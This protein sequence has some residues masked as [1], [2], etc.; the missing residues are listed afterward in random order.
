MRTTELSFLA[1]ACGGRLI[2]KTDNKVSGIKIDSR[3]VEPGDMFVAVIGENNDGHSFWRKA[4]ENGA[5]SFL[6]SD[7]AAA[8]EAAAEEG[9]GV[10]LAADTNEAFK[11]MAAAYLDQF[12]LIRVGVTG[13]VGKTTTKSL[14]AAVLSQK[15]RTVCTQKNY[16]THLGLCMTAF[17]ADETTQAIVF[18]MGMDRKGEIAGYVEWAR[19][20]AAVITNVGIS[21]MERLGSRDAIADAKLEICGR[22]TEGQPL[23]YNCGSDYLNEEEIRRR[24]P[25]PYRCVPAGSADGAIVKAY[26]VRERG[27]EGISFELCDARTGETAHVDL[28]LMGT[29]NAVNSALAAALGEEFGL[30]LAEA[31][32]GLENVQVT[33]RR[34]NAEEL[35]DGLLLIDDSYNASPDSMISGLA[36]LASVKAKRRVAVLADMYELGS[37]ENEGHTAVGRAAAE[38][39]IDFLV[40]VGKKAAYYSKGAAEIGGPTEVLSFIDVDTAMACIDSLLRPGDAVL[41]KGSNSTGI[42]AVAKKLREEHKR[43]E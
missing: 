8:E 15:Y 34:L 1:Q 29:H 25:G 3:I 33:D 28:P 27:A 24:A 14:T 11:D 40:A 9:A 30:S 42:S 6:F 7:A 13:S 26:D 35:G 21:H 36:A 43:Q 23:I 12:E 37:A 41:V 39:K 20:Q 4:Y 19:P 31:A 5:R 32:K 16:N 18:E 22:L 38:K 17:L 10:V 2:G